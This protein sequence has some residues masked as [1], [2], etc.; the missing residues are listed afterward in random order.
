MGKRRAADNKRGRRPKSNALEPQWAIVTYV[1]GAG[2]GDTGYYLDSFVSGTLERAQIEAL[3]ANHAFERNVSE[4]G[5][6]P[7]K[8]IHTFCAYVESGLRAIT[9]KP[10]ISQELPKLNVWLLRRSIA[11]EKQYKVIVVKTAVS[12]ERPDHEEDWQC[13]LLEKN[14]VSPHA[15]RQRQKHKEEMAK[16]SQDIYALT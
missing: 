4:S 10:K 15:L 9:E 7:P 8:Y 12:Q 13:T 5:A 1:L 16:I 3:A 6:E 11:G 2:P 14:W